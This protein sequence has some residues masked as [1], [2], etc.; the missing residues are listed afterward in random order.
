MLGF[1]IGF[2]VGGFAV[3]AYGKYISDRGD[4]Q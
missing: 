3:L 1:I 2:L 4:K